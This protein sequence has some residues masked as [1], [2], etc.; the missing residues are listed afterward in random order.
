MK[1]FAALA[2]VS[3]LSVAV[4]HADDLIPGS[5]APALSVKNWYK[6]TPVIKFENDKLYVVEFWATWC[7][8]CKESI[9]HLTELAHKYPKVTFVGVS[10][11]EDNEGTKIADFVKQMGAKMD[12][13][14]GWSGNQD[15]MA[16]SWMKAAGQGGIPTAFVVEHGKIDWIGHPMELEKP[17]GE[18]VAGKFDAAA[19][20]KEAAKQKAAQA[21]MQAASQEIGAADAL[22]K[23]GK[24]AEAHKKLD[25]ILAKHPSVKD[26]TEPM[27]L[28]WL[29]DEDKTKFKT[30]IT[31]YAQTEDKAKQVTILNVAM[32]IYGAH[33][34]VKP[35]AGA[36][37]PGRDMMEW[38]NE[39]TK[40]SQ[41]VYLYT[42]G[43]LAFQSKDK[44]ASTKSFDLALQV[45]DKGPFK[46]N[47]GLKNAIGELKNQ[48]AKL[49]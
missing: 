27:T 10:I 2:A 25:E 12:Y 36:V 20:A 32:Q 16:V 13:N 11:W 8:P 48:A 46:D 33:K 6:G 18:I 1:I 43:W 40:N 35:A 4:A 31:E 44:A 19:Y 14:V 26:Q 29:Y 7:G 47:V 17:L 49:P 42:A 24:H 15:G 37:E 23:S 45:F 9:P 41:A 30:K 5:P 3:A 21:E 38:V 22:F 34:G 28:G 39:A